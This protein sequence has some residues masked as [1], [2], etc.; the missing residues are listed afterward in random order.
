MGRDHFNILST[1]ILAAS[2]VA[3][4]WATKGEAQ[5]G[6]RAAPR[7]SSQRQQYAPRG[8][9][10]SPHAPRGSDN[11]P[12]YSQA[13]GQNVALEGYCPVCVVEMKKWVRGD[14]RFAARFD[15]RVYYFP[16]EEQQQMFLANPVKYT[17]VLGGDCVVCLA[18]MQK[19]MSGNIR[20]GAFHQDR[21]YLFPGEEQRAMFRNHPE[22]FANVDLAAGGNCVVCLVNMNE[23]VPGKPEFTVVYQGMRYQFPGKEQ[24]DQ[25]L[26]SPERYAQT[27]AARQQT[28]TQNKPAG[29]RF[30][31]ASLVRVTGQTGCAGCDYG[32]HPIRDA[33]ELGLAVR[34]DDGRVYIIEDAHRKYPKLYESRFDKLS[35]EVT[36]KVLKSEGEF[37]WLDPEKVVPLSPTQG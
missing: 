23:Q 27:F 30:E 35:V 6:S 31:Q 8:S 20:F 5:S 37:V 25:F 15:G 11:S 24:M 17:P 28:A 33:S 3:A 36:G 4:S 18:K 7:G 22:R 13:P 32:V 2:F 12:Q 19:R 21:L 16:G 10:N 1:V 9:D 26:S 29:V 34:S 14:A